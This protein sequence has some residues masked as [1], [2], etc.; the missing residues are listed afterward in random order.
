MCVCHHIPVLQIL[1]ILL[2]ICSFH[3]DVLIAC[4]QAHKS[5]VCEYCSRTFHDESQMKDHISTVHLG[6]TE[7]RCD[8][9]GKV[10]GS[11]I[12]LLIHQ[13]QLHERRFQQTCDGC[14]R[15]FTRLAGLINHLTRTH[16]HLLPEKY[17]RRLEEFTC[18]ECGSRFLRHS[19]LQHHVEIRHSGA[20]KYMCPKCSRRFSCRRYVLRHVRN[21]H[22]DTINTT[23]SGGLAVAVDIGKEDSSSMSDVFHQPANESSS[24]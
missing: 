19:S 11:A 10:L 9:C 20:P 6:V 4:D 15:Q 1:I 24:L 18:K 22:P 17:R 12:T 2:V 14:G 23:A 7:H 21:H 8:Q 13:R 5:F 16:P 3:C